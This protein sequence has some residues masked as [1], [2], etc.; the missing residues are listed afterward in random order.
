MFKRTQ[1]GKV[2]ETTCTQCKSRFRISERQLKQAYGKVC[3]GE[4]GCVF[5]ALNN[6]KS[7]EGELPPDYEERL[8]AEENEALAAEQAELDRTEPVYD[9]DSQAIEEDSDTAA[10]GLSLHEAMYGSE[11]NARSTSPLAWFIGIL[12]L[13]GIG[14]AQAIYYQR[15][16]LVEQPR[17]QQQVMTLCRFLPCSESKF[18]ST[19]QIRLLERNVFTHPVID[20][21]LMV[22]GAFVNQAPFAQ[23]APELLISL[24]DVRGNLIANRLFK[25]TEYLLSERTRDRIEPGKPVQFRLEIV[26]PGTNA[27]TYEFE[28]F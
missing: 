20:D 6:L 9:F 25:P 7:F 15:Y 1:L 2:M 24:F 12:L 3:C 19:D 28:F 10:R 11:K 27:L 22:T 18:S 21:A 8:L 26:D 17:Y 23:K 13:V 4:C 5:N 14:T 16:Q